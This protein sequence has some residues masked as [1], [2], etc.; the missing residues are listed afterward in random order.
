MGATKG[1]LDLVRGSQASNGQTA[2][3]WA[4]GQPGSSQG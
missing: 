4:I 2:G 3:P 1:S